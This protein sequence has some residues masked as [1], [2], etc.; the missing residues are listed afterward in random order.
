MGLESGNADILKHIGKGITVGL[1]RKAFKAAKE[2]GLLRR[3]YVL[4][5]TPLETKETIR[6][7]EALIDEVR[8]DTVSFSILAPYPGT[9]YY[10]PEFADW[11][12][13]HIDEYGGNPNQYHNLDRTKMNRTDLLAERLRLI[14]K[15]KGHLSGIMTKKIALGVIDTGEIALNDFETPK[16]DL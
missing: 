4:M 9:E 14:E 1:T 15:Y 8:P 6:E 10:Q 7:T 2:A 11:E 16:G 3:A 13:E 5:G 12:W